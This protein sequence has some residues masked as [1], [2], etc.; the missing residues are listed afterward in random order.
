[1]DDFEV[2][3]ELGQLSVFGPVPTDEEAWAVKPSSLRHRQGRI[4]YITE[5]NVGTTSVLRREFWER[6]VRVHNLRSQEGTFLFPD[7]GRL[8]VDVRSLGLSVAWAHKYLASNLG[9]M[10]REIEEHPD[11]YLE[12]YRSKQWLGVDG[13]RLRMEEWQSRV[14]PVRKSVL[15]S[16][17]TLSPEKSLPSPECPFPQRWSMIDG[18]TA[19]LETLEF[20]H[21]VV[22]LLKPHII[23][24]TG[25][26]H[27]Y[28][29]VAMARALRQNGF[30][31]VITYEIDQ[32]SA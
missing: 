7:D 20:L 14:T 13:L 8:S 24:E 25:T 4:V 31:K 17:E 29:A 16:D 1:M 12:N 18:N 26:W 19:E 30:G 3:P 22:R 32:E 27:G 2:F 6:G 11:Y 9:H 23:V 5:Q 28:S 15:V 10:G 21:S